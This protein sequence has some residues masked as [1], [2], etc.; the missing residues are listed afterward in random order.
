MASEQNV[1]LVERIENII[2]QIK[3]Q[4]VIIDAAWPEST[5]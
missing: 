2:I 1:I 3:G 5:E 4:K